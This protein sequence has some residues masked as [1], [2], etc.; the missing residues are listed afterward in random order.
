MSPL[1]L[2]RAEVQVRYDTAF[3]YLNTNGAVAERWGHG[4]EFS[5]WGEVPGQI[6]LTSQSLNPDRVGIVGIRVSGVT[7]HLPPSI[8]AFRDLASPFVSDCLDSFR[9]TV[10]RQVVMRQQW[11]MPT[12]T[13][14]DLNARLVREYPQVGDII[15]PDYHHSFSGLSFNAQ[16]RIGQE[17]LRIS[18]ILGVYPP[19]AA[20]SYF[21]NIF[22][23]DD[24][25]AL[26][27][28]IDITLERENGIE[29]ALERMPSL[30]NTCNHE[31]EEVLRH[32]IRRF[33]DV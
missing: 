18:N 9:P 8:G 31:V 22:E 4:P 23:I 12:P 11:I 27:S 19:E 13:P 17:S 10:V 6:T 1:V 16:R 33:S 5:A 28:F 29:R 24:T 15:P 25:H 32:G 2:R 14:E 30:I 20:Q 26:G 3:L 7:W 21:G